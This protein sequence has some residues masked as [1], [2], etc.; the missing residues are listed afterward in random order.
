[1]REFHGSE[2]VVSVRKAD[3]L[4]KEHLKKMAV[5]LV[6]AL[7]AGFA[8]SFSDILPEEYTCVNEEHTLTD[9]NKCISEPVYDE[10]TG[11]MVSE[12]HRATFSSMKPYVILIV[13]LPVVFVLVK[14]SW[15]K[16]GETRYLKT[17]LTTKWEYDQYTRKEND[18]RQK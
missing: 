14:P 16:L 6:S 3:V 1:M 8:L 18:W 2:V 13:L 7:I 9:D 17:V 5:I 15:F 12:V 4:K 11:N 10:Q